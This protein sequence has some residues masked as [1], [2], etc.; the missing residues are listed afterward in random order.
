M[1][2][3]VISRQEAQDRGYKRYFLG[4]PCLHGHVAERMVSNKG[5]VDCLLHN[6]IKY[7]HENRDVQLDRMRNWHKE[8]TIKVRERNSEWQ[9]NNKEIV[10]SISRNRRAL[11]KGSTG[12]H[13]KRDVDQ[14]LKLQR[15]KCACCGVKLSTYHVDHIVPLARGGSNDKINLQILCA[16]CNLQKHAKDPLTFMQERGFLL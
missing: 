7:H 4:T 11:K 12:Q 10:A 5:C 14:L 3:T 8:N 13:S 6:R 15:H 1:T 2:H 16:T 9:S